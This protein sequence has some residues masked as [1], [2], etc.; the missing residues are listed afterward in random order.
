MRNAVLWFIQAKCD[1]GKVR[2]QENIGLT[3]SD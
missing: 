3:L 1:A 2:P